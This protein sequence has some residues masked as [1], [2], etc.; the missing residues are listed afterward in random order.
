MTKDSIHE[1]MNQLRK[2]VYSTT[3][4]VQSSYELGEYVESNNIEGAVIECGIASGGNFGAMICGVLM[5]NDKP[6]RKFYGFDSFEGIQLA[7]A[8]DDIQAGIGA[9]THDISVDPKELLKS[10]GITVHRKSEVEGKFKDLGLSDT[11]N[12][13]F[14]EGWVQNTITKSKA[15]EIGKIAIL[16][17]DM[18]VYD[19]TYHTLEMLYDNIV[20]GGII[21]IDDWN[22]KGVQVAVEEFMKSRNKDFQIFNIQ[23]SDPIYFFK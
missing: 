21:I 5:A 18:D 12:I 19:P 20:E 9:I 1:A 17:L 16:R 2:M 7:G 8:K 23:N 6:K 14:V 11:V 15:K 13:E 22:L 3:E 4:T 10:S